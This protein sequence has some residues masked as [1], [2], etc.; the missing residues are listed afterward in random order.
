M[1]DASSRAEFEE[2]IVAVEEV[3]EQINA[4]TLPRVL[5]FNKCDLLTVIE[6]QEALA[7]RYVMRCSY[8]QKQEE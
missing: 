4:Q 1:V 7:N 2:R 3:L 6:Q 5:V 8:R